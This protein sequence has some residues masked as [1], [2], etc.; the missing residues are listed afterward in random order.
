M[1][2]AQDIYMCIHDV[3][4]A[5]GTMNG[6]RFTKFVRNV[7]LPHLNPFDSVNPRFVVIMDNATI[8]HGDQV[9]DLIE[10]QAG[11]KLFSSTILT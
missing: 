7:L 2:T 8:H 3:C 11:T 6:E 4:I 9:V 1:H 10:R 5:E